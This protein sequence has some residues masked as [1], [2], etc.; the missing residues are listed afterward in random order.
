MGLWPIVHRPLTQMCPGERYAMTE[1]HYVIKPVWRPD[2]PW[3]FVFVPE[4]FKRAGR[5][6]CGEGLACSEAV[7]ARSQRTATH[8]LPA[9]PSL[10]PRSHNGA[11]SLPISLGCIKLVQCSQR[12]WTAFTIKSI[13]SHR[14]LNISHIAWC[15]LLIPDMDSYQAWDLFDAHKMFW[16]S[17]TVA[18]YT[19][20]P[21]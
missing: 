14:L 3:S 15:C 17:W 19:Q 18:V 16:T 4:P 13:V 9:P 8:F 11:L 7:I 20:V 10:S 21:V 6:T 1:G 2:S 12:F 5:V